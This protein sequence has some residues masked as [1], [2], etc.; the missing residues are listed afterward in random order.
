MKKRLLTILI[1]I[2]AVC[3]AAA[4]R[5]QT[6]WLNPDG[7][8]PAIVHEDQATMTLAGALLTRD[9]AALTGGNAVQAVSTDACRNVCV[10]VGRYDSPLVRTLLEEDGIELPRLAWESYERIVFE[11]RR[12]PGTKIL[13]IAGADLRGTVY[14]VVDLTRELGVS[15]WEWW[16]DVQPARRPRLEV[17]AGRVRSASPHVRYRGI[18]LNDEDWGL[19]PWA[20]KHDPSKDIG[21]ATYARIFELMWRLKA[22]VI[23]P[24]MHDST[25][26]F[27]QI[28]GN[29][30]TARD[31]AIVVGT[32]HA[33]PMMRNNVREWDHK[34]R[35]AFNFFENRAS[36]VRYWDE[37]VKQVK[38]FENIYSVGIRGVHDSAM[39]GAR[40]VE[41]ARQGVSDAIAVQRGLLGKALG[42][43]ADQVSQALTLY[44]E[45]LDIYKAGLQVPDDIILVWPDDNYGYLHQLSTPQEAQRPGGAGIYYHISYWGR[46]HDYLWLGTTHPALIRDQLERA[47]ATDA[48]K[49]WIVNVGDI[50]PAEYLTQY[51]L[52]LAFDRKALERPV[53]E[54][55]A[56][57]MAAQFGAAHG[58]EI[59]AIMEEYYA[60][61]WERRPEFMG[62]SQTEPTTP[63]RHTDYLRSGDGEAEA[64]LARYD[65]LVARADALAGNLPGNLADAYFQLVQYPVRSSANLNTRILRLELAAQHAREGRPGANRQAARAQAAQQAIVADTARYNALGG[66]KWQGMMDAAPRRLPVFKAPAFPTY[67]QAPKRQGCS[68]VYPFPFSSDGAQVN[69]VAGRPAART[70]TL[71][72]DAGEA[73]SWLAGAVATSLTLSQS[74]G[75]LD[76]DNGF[77]QRIEI[78]YDGGAQPPAV[79]LHCGKQVLQVKLRLQAD[80][81]PGLPVER[82]RIVTIPAVAAVQST[83]SAWTVVP[84]LGS[85]GGSLRSRLAPDATAMTGMLRYEFATVSQGRAQLKVV[86]VPVHP[87]TSSNQLRIAVSMDGGAFQELDFTTHGRSDEWKANVLG[88]A[89][90]RTVVLDNLDAGR[91]VLRIRAL[92]P[93]F[94]LD[95]VELSFD[96]APTFYGRPEPASVR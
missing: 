72:G 63:V 40:N 38:G 52:D 59:A 85:F 33:E 11:P 34:Q 55:L 67:A 45:V 84:G 35:G 53:H 51:F 32:S 7:R 92:D 47:T 70:I 61:A 27:Y 91:H 46:P 26:P 87:L 31:Y 88:N 18:F 73:H 82:E 86:T 1:T 17:A 44:K 81:A 96:G 8:L 95:R 16:A 74:G 62:F 37:R 57:W 3:A 20:A 6:L 93:G 5:A 12:R 75:R 4:A 48:R 39:E 43:P 15:A 19:Q 69:F 94:V 13:L 23:W 50:K 66:G 30:E 56:D 36:L 77:E 68:I 42:K 76:A 41:E 65:A 54:H 14:G 58:P 78:R 71:V 21:P 49:L 60:L 9:L 2:A 89:A 28:A 64:R 90:L 83:P 80:P 25:K 10:V 29:A 24:A 79:S 22:N